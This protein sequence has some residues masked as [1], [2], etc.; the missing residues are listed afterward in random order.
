[1]RE[2]VVQVKVVKWV[3]N[4]FCVEKFYCECLKVHAGML[5]C[6]VDFVVILMVCGKC[7]EVLKYMCWYVWVWLGVVRS[8]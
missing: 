8:I 5:L 7:C 3:S 1:M 6:R 4:L 2:L